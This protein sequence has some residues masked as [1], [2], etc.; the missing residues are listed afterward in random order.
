VRFPVDLCNT[1]AANYKQTMG[2]V[3]DWCSRFSQSEQDAI[4]GKA[5]ARFYRIEGA[6][7]G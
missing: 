3:E 1:V 7:N 5:C 4:L 2:I 6:R